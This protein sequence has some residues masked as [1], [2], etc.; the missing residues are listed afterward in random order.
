[1]ACVCLFVIMLGHK[2]NPELGDVATC[3][4]LQSQVSGFFV[5]CSTLPEVKVQSLFI[6]TLCGSAVVI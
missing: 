4:H 2:A 1:M 5:F 3:Q 6:L